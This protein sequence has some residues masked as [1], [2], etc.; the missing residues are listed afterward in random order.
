LATS[1]MI[2]KS[3]FMAGLPMG[4]VDAPIGDHCRKHGVSGAFAPI[5]AAVNCT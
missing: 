3:S 5:V 2:E 4:A 1:C